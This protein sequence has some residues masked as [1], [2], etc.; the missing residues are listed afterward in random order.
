MKRFLAFVLAIMLT[1]QT[2]WAAGLGHCPPEHLLAPAVVDHEHGQDA[3]ALVA[4]DGHRHDHGSKSTSP[5]TGV[6]CS[7]FHFLAL[8]PSTTA[9]ASLARAAMIVP[10]IAHCG[11]KSHVSEG[12]DRPRWR[13]AV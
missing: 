9:A 1:A 11:Y 6:D 8:D 2:A 10:P 3:S 4:G 13:P 12:P 7:A 5:A